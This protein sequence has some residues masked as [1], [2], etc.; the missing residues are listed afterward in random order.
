[1]TKSNH[2]RRNVTGVLALMAG[3]IM[4]FQN[5]GDKQSSL[6]NQELMESESNLSFAKDRSAVQQIDENQPGIFSPKPAIDITESNCLQG[7]SYHC[8]LNRY[9]PDLDG[10]RGQRDLCVVI[11]GHEICTLVDEWTYDSSRALQLCEDCHGSDGRPGGRYNYSEAA[12]GFGDEDA[13]PQSSYLGNAVNGD[14]GISDDYLS[15]GYV[16][17]MFREAVSHCLVQARR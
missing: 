12:C 9:A 11:E 8:R 7:A 6:S 16:G 1:M 15:R 17:D 4:L 14:G 10:G 2:N 5:C 3:L 13:P